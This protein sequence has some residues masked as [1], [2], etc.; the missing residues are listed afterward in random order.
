MVE[1]RLL[2]RGLRVAVCNSDGVVIVA[3][4]YLGL[5]VLLEPCSK[6]LQL[7][8]LFLVSH[9]QC[10]CQAALVNKSRHTATHRVVNIPDVGGVV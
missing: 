1:P 2:K 10:L 6:S 4:L 5:G 8:D 9:V 7:L 3:I